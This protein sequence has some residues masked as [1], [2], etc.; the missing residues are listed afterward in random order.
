[1]KFKKDDRVVVV[2][3]TDPLNGQFYKVGNAGSVT[4][5][6]AYG[7]VVVMFDQDGAGA[8][9][10]WFVDEGDLALHEI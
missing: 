10:S 9:D 3:L 4:E 8:H 7:S 6:S 2:K 1:M 5:Y